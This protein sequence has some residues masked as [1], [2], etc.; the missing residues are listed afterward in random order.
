MSL[1]FKAWHTGKVN[2]SRPETKC[3]PL[4]PL[5]LLET[6]GLIYSKC[7]KLT[8]IF[9]IYFILFSADFKPLHLQKVQNICFNS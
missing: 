3:K 8:S 2:L 9:F 6:S 7:Q 1:F 5:N 4:Q